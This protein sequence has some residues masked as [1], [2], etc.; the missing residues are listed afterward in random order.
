MRN[1]LVSHITSMVHNYVSSRDTSLREAV[2]KIGAELVDG[3][4]EIEK[5]KFN[6]G[7]GVDG[8]LVHQKELLG[9]LE[10]RSSDG[11]RARDSGGQALS[12]VVS[13]FHDGL[14]QVQTLVG[15]ASAAQSTVVSKETQAL[16]V[17]SAGALER[18]EKSR[19]ARVE[20]TEAVQA[21]TQ[22]SYESLQHVLALTSRVVQETVKGIVSDV[23]VV[24]RLTY[25]L[26]TND[27]ACGRLLSYEM[28]LRAIVLRRVGNLLAYDIPR[29]HW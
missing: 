13:G 1:E 21:E 19:R 15:Q 5:F 23:S 14:V 27:M 11:R 22:Q 9:R 24:V 17:A 20:H 16:D 3:Q 10:K 29:A 26:L 6:H 12:Q 7:S 25:R 28:L 8:S 2:N 18:L 4:H